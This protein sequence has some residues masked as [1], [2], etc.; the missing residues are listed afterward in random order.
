MNFSIEKDVLLKTV[1]IADAAVSSKNINSSL[2][3]CLFSISKNSLTISGTDNDIAIRHTC[4]IISDDIFS[5]IVNGK[6]I[7]QIVKEL[8]KGEVDISVD[9]SYGVSIKSRSKEVKGVY[10]VIGSENIDY[11]IIPDFDKSKCFSFDQHVFKEMIRRV[12]YAASNDSIKPAFN[13]VYI[14]SE[15]SGELSVVAS[16]SRRLSISTNS[17]N[18][19]FFQKEGIIIPL[20]TINEIIKVLSSGEFN[21]YVNE[22]QCFFRI[23][24]TEI[25]S[26]I[27][28]G[29]FPNYKQVIPKDYSSKIY[30]PREKLI[31]TIRRI[32]VFTKEPSYKVI[33]SFTKDKLLI[34][35][36]T[37]EL[38]EAS[39]Y[40][41]IE[42]NLSDK[43]TIGI[44]AQY[45]Y[46]SVKEIESPVIECGINGPMN[47]VTLSPEGDIQNLAIIMPIQIKSSDNE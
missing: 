10:K 18:E 4:D 6:K 36:R 21:F 14:I 5:F 41:D 31:E 23:G 29:Q 7:I 32:I 46:D 1:S 35:S 37:A 2:G 28:D 33:V 25:V 12:S 45:V 47:P 39:E 26:R 3:Y 38:G 40:I 22:N 17:V 9:T 27:I 16:D 34:E 8:P 30:I 42:S 15:K 13:G 24:Q 19:S 20:K 43:I 11:P 44:N